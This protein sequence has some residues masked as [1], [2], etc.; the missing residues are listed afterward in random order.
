MRRQ[1]AEVHMRDGGY[2]PTILQCGVVLEI[3]TNPSYH[4]HNLE[5][6]KEKIKVKFPDY[7]DAWEWLASD[8]EWVGANR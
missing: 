6:F 5:R 8:F 4:K 2:P 7:D 1:A 3:T